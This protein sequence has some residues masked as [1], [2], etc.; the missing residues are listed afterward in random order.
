MSEH[1]SVP[2]DFG[3]AAPSAIR[4]LLEVSGVGPRV[5]Q[6]LT[7][8][9]DARRTSSAPSAL[10]TSLLDPVADLV[11]H[12]G[13]RL[14]AAFCYW[15]WRSAGG[16]DCAGVVAAAAALELLHGCA[17][18]HDDV[19]DAS[20]LR[21]GR[22]AVH[23][24]FASQH[25]DAGWHG[26][27]AEFGTAAAILAGDLCL[28]WADEMLRDSG[29]PMVRQHRA[30]SVFNAMREETIRGQYLDL[31]AQAEGALRVQDARR[32]AL[33]KTAASTTSGPLT[34]GAVLAAASPALCDGLTD[35]AMPLGLAFQ[36]RDDLHGAFGD[37]ELTGKPSGDD[38]RDGKCT[39]LLAQARRLGGPRV[40]E[41][42]ADL[43]RERP[44]GM[45][46]ELR[47]VLDE[48]GARNYVEHLIGDLGWQAIAALEVAP[49]VDIQA[50]QVLHGFA[51][52][53]TDTDRAA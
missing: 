16:E 6:R 50:R 52:A 30:G 27:P 47:T 44:I 25:V 12:G 7:D 23:R 32:V 49:I 53:L 9:F 2:A 10:E 4:D 21:R 18:I 5:E 14:R 39:V 28:V 42:I 1:M 20:D 51:A 40:A 8:F 15:G 36:L 46:D 34:F 22:P 24:Q 38:L 26:S 48:A 3:M 17:L 11:L 37:P 31:A 29:L 33:A 13:K 35:Y 43:L 45:V 41:R 19:M